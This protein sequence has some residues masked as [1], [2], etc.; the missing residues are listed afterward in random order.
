MSLLVKC[1]TLSLFGQKGDA[2]T[3]VS[4]NLQVKIQ[5]ISL[6]GADLFY[7]NSKWTDYG[8]TDMTKLTVAFGSCFM[9]VSKSEAF[10]NTVA[11]CLQK[12]RP[13][14]LTA[15]MC[16]LETHQVFGRSTRHWDLVIVTSINQQAIFCDYTCLN[17]TCY[18]GAVDKA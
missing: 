2:A 1:F 18:N 14:T 15:I 6:V 8:R 11:V 4:Q 5:W 12:P 16:G 9:Q 3:D 13:W 17:V 10:K 7:K